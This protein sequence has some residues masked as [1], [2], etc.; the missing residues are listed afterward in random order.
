MR[1]HIPC[2]VLG[3]IFVAAVSTTAPAAPAVT[4]AAMPAATAPTPAQTDRAAGVVM[5]T[6]VADYGPPP[7]NAAPPPAYGG[8]VGPAA[9]PGGPVP[10][11]RYIYQSDRILVV[12]PVT[13]IAMQA[14]PR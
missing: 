2:A 5:P 14:L 7:Y 8:A 13:G 10:A 9:G 6:P 3:L 12:D 4:A 1:V 11:Y